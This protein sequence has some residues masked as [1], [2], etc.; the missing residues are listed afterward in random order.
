MAAVLSALAQDVEFERS[1]ASQ[2]RYRVLRNQCFV[3]AWIANVDVKRQLREPHILLNVP[4]ESEESLVQRV[5]GIH[6]AAP[7]G[8]CDA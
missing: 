8:T 2:R 1:E 3:Q 4:E 7:N 6:R 5:L